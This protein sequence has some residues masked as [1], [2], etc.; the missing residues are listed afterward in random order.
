M[1]SIILLFIN[2]IEYIIIRLSKTFDEAYYLLKY[3]DCRLA[4]VD[5]VWH[6][7]RFGWR[8]GRKP[9]PQLDLSYYIKENS[10][11]NPL[12]NYILGSYIKTLVN[13]I[14]IKLYFLIPSKYRKH[15]IFIAYQKIGCLLRYTSDYQFWLKV[16][17]EKDLYLSRLVDID[18]LA[19]I[20][21]PSGGIAAH[22]HIFY[23]DLVKEMLRHVDNIPFEYDLFITSSHDIESELLKNRP[24]AR[25]IVFIKIENRGRNIAPLFCHL[26]DKLKNYKYIIHVH[27]K[28]SLYNNGATAGWLEYL[29]KNL[30]GSK[31]RIE[32]I[33]SLFEQDSSIG[34]VYPQNYFLLPSWANTWLAN[35]QLGRAWCERLGF[36]F[37]RGYFDYPAGSMFWARREA[38]D[39]LF[40]ANIELED[41]PEEKGQNDG[42]LAH[43]I[44]RLIVLSANKQG[45]RAA[46]ISDREFPSWSPWRFEQYTN[47]NV[48]SIIQYI[49]SKNIKVLIFDIFDTLVTRP[50]LNPESIKRIVARHAE[51]RAGQL[52]L[53]HRRTAEELTRLDEGRDVTLF[54]I[55]PRLQQL[56]GLPDDVVRSLLETE[57]NLEINSVSP[58]IEAI[59]LMNAIKINNLKIILASDMFLSLEK[60]KGILK[61][62]KIYNYTDVFVSS[63]LGIRKDTGDL[64]KHILKVYNVKPEEVAVIGDNERSDMQIPCDMGMVPIHVLR[65]VELARGLPRWNSLV[66]AQEQSDNLDD[67][68]QLGIVIRK[69]FSAIELSNLD[70]QQFVQVTP[71]HLGYSLVGPLLVSF[72][73]WLLEVSQRDGIQKLYFLSREGK[74]IK[75]VFDYWTQDLVNRP[76]S[77]YLVISRRSASVASISNI[78]DVFEIARARFFPGKLRNF[79]FYRYGVDI[80]KLKDI[81]NV[82][83]DIEIKDKNISNIINILKEIYPFILEQAQSERPSLLA[84]LKNMNMDDK[85]FNI[86]VVDIGY[87]AT[88]QACLN[89]LIE[90]PVHGYYIMTDERAKSVSDKYKVFVKGWLYENIFMQSPN[91]PLIAKLSFY[92]EKVLSACE[93]QLQRYELRDGQPVAVYQEQSDAELTAHQ[94][95]R[96]IQRG[97]MDYALEARHVRQTLLPDFQPGKTIPTALWENFLSQMSAQEVAL[98]DKIALDDH[99]CGRGVV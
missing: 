14:G 24:K 77:S 37:P 53:E 90:R 96:E 15:I 43:V 89:R 58:R 17:N 83:L 57:E 87:G 44:E 3:P 47:R 56:T 81:V 95:R 99:Y 4:D 98:M 91:A 39:P 13:R 80:Y 10:L 51:L 35:Y 79:I 22:V 11:I 82:E 33:I 42:T 19:D 67:E 48:D 55:A 71:Y 61:N 66:H 97:A 21:P 73:Q 23:V 38:L 27:T 49:L 59:N 40:D 88:I 18:S 52:Y 20:K 93:P 32:K 26:R 45:L 74:I 70:P 36:R 29:L 64:Y 94:I 63:S 30:L 69:N 5:P 84:Y 75:E 8:E 16:L 60:I 92:L 68:L 46:I 28:K 31:D 25:N 78:E 72:A 12:T 9:S 76:I 6:F 85:E 50:L 1:K 65:P 7:I 2:T 54:E 34:I 41:F 62:N 86:A